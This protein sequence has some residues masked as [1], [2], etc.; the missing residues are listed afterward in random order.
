[1]RSLLLVTLILVGCDETTP[2]MDAGSDA[3]PPA[4]LD[5]GE[6]PLPDPPMSEPG[7]H[8]VTVLETRR[9]IP[10]DGFPAETVA[11]HSNNNLDVIRHDGRV[12]LAWRT[13]PDHYAGPDTV[14]H[15]V[16]SADELVWDFE[17]SYTM[18]TDLREPRFL[19]L[20]GSLFLY[21]AVLGSN[22]LAFEP[23]GVMVTERRAD[24][25]WTALE[26]VPGLDGYIAWR[27]RT[28]RGTP[29]MTAYLGG[30]HIYL[31]DGLP[32]SVDLLTTTDGRAWTPVDPARRTIYMGGGSETDFT[33]GDDGTLFGI[34]RNEAGDDS[35]WG[36]MVCRA[37]AGDLANWD[38]HNDPRKY[39]SPLMFWHDGEAYLVGRRQVT[40]T[41]N[42]DLMTRRGTHTAQTA[43]NQIPYTQT[44][45]RCALW[46]YVQSEDRIAFVL[47]LPSGGDTCFPAWLEGESADEIVL[48]NYSND[49]DDPATA[50]LAWNQGQVGD[51]FIYRHV[52]RFTPR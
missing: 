52:L 41:G 12:Y 46:R 45:K 44:P 8:D 40:Q 3:G 16:S 13:A 34:I 38:C 39:D 28:E 29:Y 23:M 35:G 51:T 9:V 15:V 5:A 2:A 26:A 49:V 24:G 43:A 7:R 22:Q 1:M 6:Q 47:D 27:T 42:Y 50:R 10:G 31:F 32:L 37:P 20:G 48:Y 30:E 4:A 25:T 19:S 21:I 36:S 18:G 14:I 33:I 17:G 11:Q